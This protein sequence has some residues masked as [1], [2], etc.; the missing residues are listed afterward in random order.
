M[1][2]QK[3]FRD[4]ETGRFVESP[5]R[6]VRCEKFLRVNEVVT[7][8]IIEENDEGHFSMRGCDCCSNGLGTTVY[9]CHGYSEK[10][11]EVFE[12]G[13][14][15]HECICYFYNGEDSEVES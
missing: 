5:L 2:T 6:S 12:L 7:C 3:L 15:C 8:S 14:V 10:H 11:K 4:A 1:K 13:S 9:E